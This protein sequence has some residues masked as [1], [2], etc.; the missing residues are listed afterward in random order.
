MHKLHKAEELKKKVDM[1]E[2]DLGKIKEE[3][4]MRE[5]KVQN[6]I[7]K[8]GEEINSLK[9]KKLDEASNINMLKTKI[10]QA[11]NDLA[12][13]VNE[14]I[15]QDPLIK[16]LNSDYEKTQSDFR[17]V[18]DELFEY[19]NKIMNLGKNFQS[20]LFSNYIFQKRN[21]FKINSIF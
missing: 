8:L 20:K 4:N 17:R 10:N 14:S 3:F 11:K 7:K 5:E 21:K 16:K 1:L 15:R 18:H 19:E 12:N 6:E 13:S 9:E 2:N